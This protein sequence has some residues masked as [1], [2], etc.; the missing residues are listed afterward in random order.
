MTTGT[1][2]DTLFRDLWSQ[3]LTECDIAK[4]LG[5]SR[6]TVARRARRLGLRR[7]DPWTEETTRELIVLRTA[8]VPWVECAEELGRDLRVV[9]RRGVQL[10]LRGGR[11]PYEWKRAA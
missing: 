4:R 6:S 5:V 10:G 8:G 1:I 7:Y 9:M 3:D 2:D 11:D